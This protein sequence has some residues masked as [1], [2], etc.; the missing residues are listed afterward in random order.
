MVA[1]VAAEDVIHEV[2]NLILKD[3]SVRIVTEVAPI[4]FVLALLVGSHGSA[5]QNMASLD[6]EIDQI[7]NNWQGARWRKSNQTYL[8]PEGAAS[9][10]MG[11]KK[12]EAKEGLVGSGTWG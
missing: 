12:I 9:L 11:M 8:E 10:L 2:F 7:L 4:E 6:D 5:C 1:S 3:G